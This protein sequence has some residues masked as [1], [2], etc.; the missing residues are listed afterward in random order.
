MCSI[1]N[2]WDLVSCFLVIPSASDPVLI[3][4]VYPHLSS[5]RDVS[6]V[7]D[8]RFGGAR[9]VELII[10]LL[11]ERKISNGKIGIVEPDF[12]AFLA[13][14]IAKWRHFSKD[15]LALSYC[16]APR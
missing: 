9:S 4:G 7:R 8:V 1:S 10:S 2:H 13:S 5:I 11:K 3:T 6:V 12:F 15:C 16:F 14:P